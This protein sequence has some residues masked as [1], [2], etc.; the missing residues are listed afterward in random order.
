M[1]LKTVYSRFYKSFNFDH[2]RKAHPGAKAKPWE[3]FRNIWYPY[4]EV[5]ID[6]EI[7]T[8]V[9]ANESGKSHLLSGIDKAITGAGFKQRDLCRYSPFFNVERGQEC[10]PHLGL[11]WV[12]L[13]PE[14]TEALRSKVPKAPAAFTEFHMFREGPD[15]LQ[16]YFPVDGDVPATITLNGDD[17]RNFATDLLPRPFKIKADVALPNSVPLAWLI[18]PTA[19][20]GALVS[21]QFRGY[22]LETFSNV[23]PLWPAEAAQVPTNLPVFFQSLNPL[24]GPAGRYKQEE[25]KIPESALK[26]ARDLLL[27]V[28][29]IEPARLKDLHEAILEGED[30]HANA[31]V[32]QI[33]GQ[34]AKSLNFPKWWVQDRD[35]ALRI[36]IREQD[37]VFTIQDRT[38]TEYTFNERSSG[39]RYFLSYLIQS[40]ARERNEKDPIILSMDEPDAYLSAEAQQDLLKIFDDFACPESSAPPA[41]VIFV[42][43]SPFLID[44]NHAERIRV[45]EKGKGQ[46]GTR[47][48]KN[49]SRNHYEPLRSAF[50]AFVGETAFIGACNLLVEGAADQI[51]LSGAARIIRDVDRVAS[52]ETLDLNRI[53]IVP[54]GSAS[55]VP[56]M[57]Y[58]ARGRDAEKPPVIALLDSDDEGNKAAKLLREE[59][60]K[61][62]RLIKK[63][64]MMQVHELV[65]P[66]RVEGSKALEDLMPTSLA[67][68]AANQF[69]AEVGQY[70]DVVAVDLTTAQVDDKVR[71]DE[72]I[73]AAMNLAAGIQ[74]FHIE[75]IGFARAA[76]DQ[77]RVALRGGELKEAAET[78]I[79]RLRVVFK[80]LNEAKRLA[81]R[82][83]TRERV[84]SKVQRYES[85]FLKDHPSQV[86]KEQA[87]NFLEDVLD[88]LDESAESDPVRTQIS[89]MKR[90]FELSDQPTSLV[91]DFAK[92]VDD[93]KK[94]KNAFALEQLTKQEEG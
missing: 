11:Q 69:L 31:L 62:R 80:R 36:T 16:L 45:L 42:T 87:Q 83:S 76:I 29:N 71:R 39:L 78:F 32:A 86:T 21:R 35:F 43:H 64:Y 47:V 51:I 56:Y 84:G 28:A 91:Q 41:Q 33:N 37:L 4:I 48:I 46:D 94:L 1:K 25:E 89:T 9:G 68:A 15:T 75:K 55:Q 10:W 77:C 90:D 49:A 81:E 12:E 50:G 82:D 17:A 26:L 61:M 67:V 88:V 14:E 74:G 65:D 18:S 2:L 24:L 63:D 93:V 13:S 44:R 54:C 38:G 66:Q 19:S 70:R 3:T 6:R 22:V 5:P 23:I 52:N 7:T 72:G 27:H 60:K 85:I 58:L 79:S 73:F 53:V 40:Q 8:V 59:G 57:L 30:G 92:F 34:L 20:N